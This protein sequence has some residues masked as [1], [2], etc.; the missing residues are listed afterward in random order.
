MELLLSF[1]LGFTVVAAGAALY[2]AFTSRK[3]ALRIDKLERVGIVYQPVIEKSEVERKPENGM[4]EPAELAKLMK[5]PL[6]MSL[7]QKRS[8]LERVQQ[9]QVS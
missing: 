6:R 8:F 7:S 1:I 9:R 3:L 2:A 4:L 5:S